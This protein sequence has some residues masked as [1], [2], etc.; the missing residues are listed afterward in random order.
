MA[1]GLTKKEQ[2]RRT[3]ERILEE[4]VKLFAR[5]GFT[6]TSTQ[7]LAKALGMTPGV[8]YWHFDSKEEILAAALE[9]LFSRTFDSITRPGEGIDEHD[10]TTTLRTLIH[11]VARVMEGYVDWLHMIGVVSAEST[12]THPRIEESLRVA[13]RKLAELLESV[14][15]R[16]E[17]LGH[18][19]SPALP[20]RAC[21]AQMFM[22]L[23]MG[24]LMHQRLFRKEI[25][26]ARAMPI[27]ERMLFAAVL[28]GA[29][30]SSSPAGGTPHGRSARPRG[31]RAA[32]RG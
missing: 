17:K 4:A 9:L 25:P 23:Y 30:I 19:H 1:T 16:A 28:P 18:G 14:L 12:E 3:R 5:R 31:K 6:S 11:R 7:D 15:A 20:D 32:R 26:I 24:A 22:G 10:P 21:A 13:Y 27:V 29:A 8:L 2:A